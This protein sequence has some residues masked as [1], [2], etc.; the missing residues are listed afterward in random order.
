MMMGVS[1]FIM[2]ELKNRVIFM[3]LWIYKLDLWVG[4]VIC[5]W[6]YFMLVIVYG[7]KNL[8]EFNGVRVIWVLSFEC[9]CFVWENVWC[10]VCLIVVFF[11]KFVF[12]YGIMVFYIWLIWDMSIVGY[13]C[14][15]YCLLSFSGYD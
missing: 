12:V 1:E 14:Y 11:L 13:N 15:V 4:V 9:L 7:K 10:V 3:S 5:I 8:E 6:S 2:G